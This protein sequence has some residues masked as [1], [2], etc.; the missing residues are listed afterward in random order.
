MATYTIALLGDGGV[1]KSSFLRALNG[2]FQSYYIPTT[3]IVTTTHV[4][5]PITLIF[6]DYAGQEKYSNRSFEK[7]DLAIIMYDV[8]NKMS[9]KNAQNYWKNYASTTPTIY[10]AN[11][12][13]V[14][15]PNTDDIKI[16]CKTPM[17]SINKLMSKIQSRLTN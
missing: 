5:G 2:T 16:S 9:Y 1:G 11:K 12:C 3:G 17:N 14:A 6:R 13:D 10:V 8:T 4:Q 15:V 7:A